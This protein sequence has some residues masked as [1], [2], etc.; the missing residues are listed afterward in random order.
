MT[1]PPAGFGWVYTCACPEYATNFSAVD[2][3]VD[4]CYSIT[5]PALEIDCGDFQRARACASLV[6]TNVTS[7][8]CIVKRLTP[9]PTDWIGL[10][11]IALQTLAVLLLT[12]ARRKRAEEDEEALVNELTERAKLKSEV[13]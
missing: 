6:C 7:S 4:S 1:S 2:V 13:R 12:I 8:A 5:C 11:V 3:A 9:I 10:S